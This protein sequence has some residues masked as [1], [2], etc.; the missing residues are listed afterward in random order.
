M[1]GTQHVLLQDLLPYEA[2]HNT[3]IISQFVVE[4]L[5]IRGFLLVLRLDFPALG[6]FKSSTRCH[7]WPQSPS[8]RMSPANELRARQ[9][10]EREGK[11]IGTS[12][13]RTSF[14]A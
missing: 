9:M 4:I 5:P 7:F 1:P 10:A 6:V 12:V 2:I 14:E 3:G 11:A 13:S 8:Y